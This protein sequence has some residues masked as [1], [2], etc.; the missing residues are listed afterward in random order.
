[1][2]FVPPFRGELG[3]LI[4]FHAAAVR[5]MPR[6]LTVAH[7]P[8]LEALYP[9]ARRILVRARA[10]AE[11][12]WTYGHDESFLRG[13]ES[14]LEAEDVRKPDKDNR[15]KIRPFRPEPTVDQVG[16]A[17]FDAV[18]C[19]RRRDYGPE[20]NWE[21]WPELSAKMAD[22]GLRIFAAG[23]AE[24]SYAIPSAAARAWD[25]PR[26]LDATIEAMTQADLVVATASGLSL[27]ALLC[28]VPRM[29]LV[30]ANGGKVAPG[31]ARD[32]T[33]KIAH[34]SYWKVPLEDYYEP[35]NWAGTEIHF[36]PGGWGEPGRVL[37]SALSLTR[38]KG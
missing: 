23:R 33:G 14:A 9:D 3:I 16:P 18:V 35:L 4:R 31:P 13:F 2:I 21:A 25:F 10:D 6:P 20:K 19:P 7:E 26:E 5:A 17:H 37:D 11:R 22:A 28:G 1:M 12:R 15:M 38:S 32:G 29:I 27:L 36:L 30:A 34:E 8:G 24:T